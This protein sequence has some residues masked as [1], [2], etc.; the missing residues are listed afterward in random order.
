MNMLLHQI[1]NSDHTR[2]MLYLDE[3]VKGFLEVLN[4]LAVEVGTRDF[5]R[6]E[7]LQEPHALHRT[8]RGDTFFAHV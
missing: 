6:P 1:A 2:H 7:Q 8:P 3:A 5:V 4:T